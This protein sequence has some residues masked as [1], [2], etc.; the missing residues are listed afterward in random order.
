MFEMRFIIVFFI[1]IPPGYF[2]SSISR[3]HRKMAADEADF[4]KF[5]FNTSEFPAVIVRLL[6]SIH[7]NNIYTKKKKN[8]M[9]A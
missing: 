5:D 7:I 2:S 6:L 9:G 1:I 8:R 3:E 4:N